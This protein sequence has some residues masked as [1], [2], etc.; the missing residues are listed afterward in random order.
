MGKTLNGTRKADELFGKS[1]G[2]TIKGKGGNDLIS[3]EG[4]DDKLFGG[5]GN[6][7]I[8][9]DAGSDVARG[10]AGKD[11]FIL[12]AG[13]VGRIKDFV[14]GEDVLTLA[15][16]ESGDGTTLLNSFSAA[17]FGA[18]VSYEDGILN[19]K[20]EARAVVNGPLSADDVFW[21]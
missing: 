10:G 3:G 4:G 7:T 5:K 14:V 13:D 9:L 8:L 16:D 2:D 6:D 15:I 18:F 12:G 11:V 21:F 1:G 19:Y 20:G 17:D